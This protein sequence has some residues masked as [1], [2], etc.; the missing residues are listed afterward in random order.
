MADEETQKGEGGG[1]NRR[2]FLKNAGVVVTGST[3]AA[4]IT[5][6][7]EPAQAAAEAIA[8]TLTSFRCPLCSMNFATFANLQSHFASTHPGTVVPVT[9]KLNVNGK[10]YEVLIEPHWTLQRTLQFKL[11]LTGAKQMC[12]RGVCGSCT[13]IMDGRAVLS[14]TTLAVECEGK[15]IQTVEGIAADSKW[16][17]LIDSYCKWDAMQ[18]GYCTPGFVVSAKAL[19]EKNSHPTEEDC[20]QALAGNICCCGTYPRHPTAIMEAAQNMKG[21]A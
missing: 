8:T 5:L 9:T 20:K 1:L 15:A 18:C 2:N 11:G 4:G 7:T 3:L 16:K 19:L 13:V 17:P 6:A 12:D 10:D 14:C 21:G